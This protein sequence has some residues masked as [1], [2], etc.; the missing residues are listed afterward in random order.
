M[1]DDKNTKSDI[2]NNEE[3]TQNNRGRKLP[4]LPIASPLNKA[5]GVIPSA[6]NSLKKRNQNNSLKNKVNENKAKSRTT[7]TPVNE[8]ANSQNDSETKQEDTNK[9]SALSNLPSFGDLKGNVKKFIKRKLLIALGALLPV[10]AFFL[11]FIVIISGFIYYYDRLFGIVSSA[12]NKVDQLKEIWG[13]VI[14][15]GCF[16][17]DDTCNEKAQKKFIKKVNEIENHYL[18]GESTDGQSISLDVAV[19]LATLAY[20]ETHDEFI[21]NE[22]TNDMNIT[23]EIDW[24]KLLDETEGDGVWIFKDIDWFEGGY[25]DS[26][27]EAVGDEKYAGHTS[28]GQCGNFNPFIKILDSDSEKNVSNLR[29]LAKKMVVRKVTVSCTAITSGPGLKTERIN[30][31]NEYKLD[32]DFYKKYLKES[33]FPEYYK[34]RYPEISDKKLKTL[35]REAAE[36]VF[37][38]ADFYK[39]I[40]NEILS[41]NNMFGP[42]SCHYN[43]GSDTVSDIKVRLMQCGDG[44]R[45]QPI[46]GEDLIDFEKYVLGVTYAENG[47]APT[48]SVKAQAVAARTYALTRSQGMNGSGGVSLKQ[49]NGQWILSIRNCTEDQ[50]YCDPD[51]G[52]WSNSRSAGATVH[53]GYDASK[54]YHKVAVPEDSPLRTAVAETAGKIVVDANGQIMAVGYQNTDQN[55]WSNKARQGLT[56]VEIIKQHYGAGNVGQATCTSSTG[57]I[58]GGKYSSSARL[59]VDL[60]DLRLNHSKYFDMFSNVGQC[61]WFARARAAEILA[62]SNIPE[63]L[64]T[65]AVN[66]IL[67][68]TGNGEAWFRAP[69]SKLFSKSTD[70]YAARP[71]SLV[72]WSGGT[73]NGHGGYYGHVAIIEDVKYDANGKATQVYLSESYAKQTR[74]GWENLQ[75]PTPKW[76][77]MNKLKVYNSNKKYNFQGYVYLLG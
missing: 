65:T 75:Y 6:L 34:K 22:V 9:S 47:G 30:I 29:L 27:G 7:N 33:Y 62:A 70:L 69:D 66:S 1:N 76:I 31:Q 19:L 21:D 18:R 14:T 74:S 61:V 15:E 10:I 67:S 44:T 26:E 63:P 38:D 23:G 4:N 77:D 60:Q 11:L 12:Q 20:P 8:E 5:R 17:L 24:N 48:E 49:E 3:N 71:G 53:S 25:I 45:G 36:N 68:T 35:A 2:P 32:L 50:V 16:G 55:S 56:Y 51:K 40:V 54:A 58:S 57:L 28:D 64:R 37:E 73:S 46:A 52:C 43:I 59:Y 39:E 41:D 42:I 13:N 72:S